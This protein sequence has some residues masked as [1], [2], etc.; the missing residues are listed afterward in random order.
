MFFTDTASS[1][2]AHQM[3]LS[4]TVKLNSHESLTDQPDAQPWGCDAPPGTQTAVIFKSG[5]V[6]EPAHKGLPFPCFTQ[7]G[8]IADLLDKANV[9]WRYYVDAFEGSKDADFSGG[10]WNGYDAIEKIRHGPDWKKNMSMPNTTVFTDVKSGKL[11]AVSWVIP[12]LADSDHPASGCNGGPRWVTSIVNAIGKSKYWD[13]NGDDR[14]V[15]RLGRLVRSRAAGADQLHEPRHARADDRDLAVVA[16]NT[17]VHTEYQFGSILKFIE[18]NFGL[19]SLHTTDATSTSMGDIFNFNQ[20]GITFKP[21]P[22]PQKS[23]CGG[24]AYTREI[25]EHDGGV[26]E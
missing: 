4:G 14:N 11:P 1:F 2:I 15:G 18:Q 9:S 5:K 20:S 7:Y 8:T 16:A 12:S 19:G 3:I 13:T 24:S 17:V 25:I 26:P 22:L 21:E 10:V 6:I 23:N